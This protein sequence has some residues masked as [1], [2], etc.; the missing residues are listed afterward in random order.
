MGRVR[1]WF[2]S[3]F[4][5]K[6]LGVGG[7]LPFLLLKWFVYVSQGL[8]VAPGALSRSA[9]SWAT[10]GYLNL[11]LPGLSLFWRFTKRTSSEAP[12]ADAPGDA[13]PALRHAATS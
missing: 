10:A 9:Q 6:L 3:L 12:A 4:S 2:K 11:A 13:K 5:T 7:R 1:R 8:S